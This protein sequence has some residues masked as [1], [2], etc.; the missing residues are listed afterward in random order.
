MLYYS[1]SLEVAKTAHLIN[2]EKTQILFVATEVNRPISW[3]T[4]WLVLIFISS[5]FY[6]PRIF[7]L[8][9]RVFSRCSVGAKVK[10]KRL[11]GLNTLDVWTLFNLS[12]LAYKQAS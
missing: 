3:T 10:A 8:F 7:D 11:S 9:I 6:F 5:Q 1:N 4:Q 2:R 12:M